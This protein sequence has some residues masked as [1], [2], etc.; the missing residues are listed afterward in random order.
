MARTIEEILWLYP[1]QSGDILEID[2]ISAIPMIWFKKALLTL[3]LLIGVP[4]TLLT[5]VEIINPQTSPEDRSEAAAALMFLGLPPTALGGWLG[6]NLRQRHQK[7]LEQHQL[8]QEQL[9][10]SLL[11]GNEGEVTVVQFA[12]QTRLSLEEA[13]TYLDQKAVQLNGSFDVTETGAIVYRFPL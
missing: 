2:L 10:L 5:L 1:P 4:V 3:L 8:E 7:T 6:L 12:S 11:Q 9:F 13:K